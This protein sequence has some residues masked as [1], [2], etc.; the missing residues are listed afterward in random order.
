MSLFSFLPLFV[1]LFSRLPLPLFFP[2]QFQRPLLGPFPLYSF[3][4]G[5]SSGTLVPHCKARD[6]PPQNY[7][8]MD[9]SVPIVFRQDIITFFFAT[10]SCSCGDGL[11]SIPSHLP[12][13]PFSFSRFALSSAWEKEEI[14]IGKGGNH[15]MRES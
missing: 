4:C 1:M 11:S 3:I 12:P 5:Y 13:H 10:L 9:E 8:P 6:S 2:F 15:L 14:Q 7:F